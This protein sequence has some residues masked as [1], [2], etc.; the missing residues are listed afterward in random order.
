MDQIAAQG[1]STITEPS[2]SGIVVL[3][4]PDFN[5]RDAL[6]TLLTGQGWQVEAPEDASGL[7]SLL[8]TSRITAVISEARMPG[9][10]PG[11]LLD[12]CTKKSVPV[13]FIGHSLPAQAAVDLV[14]Q[15]ARDYLEKPFSRS[16]LLELLNGFAESRPKKAQ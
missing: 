8:K 3:L 12:R 16:R 13:V 9:C 14:R 15:G 11:E 4:E 5:V 1:E 10:E 6:S 7:E 2:A